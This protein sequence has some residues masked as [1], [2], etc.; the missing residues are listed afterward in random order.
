MITA[1]SRDFSIAT[2]SLASL[3]GTVLASITFT[4][5]AGNPPPC[6]GFC[7]EHEQPETTAIMPSVVLKSRFAKTGGKFC[8]IG[9]RTSQLQRPAIVPHRE[10]FFRDCYTFCGPLC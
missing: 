9:Q 10:S 7:F 1:E 3:T 8:R 5:I 2:Y 6:C 4:G